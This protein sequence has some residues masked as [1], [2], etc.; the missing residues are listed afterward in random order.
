MTDFC[1]CKDWDNLKNNNSHVFQWDPVYGWVLY[2]VELTSEEGYTQIHRYGVPIKF[3]PM[4]GKK[5]KL[6]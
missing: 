2:W 3:C 6:P 4:C 1:G 5:L